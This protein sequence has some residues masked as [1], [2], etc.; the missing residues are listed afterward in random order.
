MQD[1]LNVQYHGYYILVTLRSRSGAVLLPRFTPVSR[2]RP[3]R[4]CRIYLGSCE[5]RGPEFRCGSCP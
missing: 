1:F 5:L 2:A 4:P 3:L